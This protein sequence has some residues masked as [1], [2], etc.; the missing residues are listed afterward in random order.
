MSKI[1]AIQHNYW[2]QRRFEIFCKFFLTKEKFSK[3][4]TIIFKRNKNSTRNSMWS[5]EYLS[6][7]A[8]TSRWRNR[9][10]GC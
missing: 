3:R 5:W 6:F 1:H 2:L 7:N 9:S 4:K 10:M 8:S